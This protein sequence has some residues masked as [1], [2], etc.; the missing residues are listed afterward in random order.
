M[1]SDERLAIGARLRDIRVQRGLTQEEL[2]QNA[3]LSATH[4]SRMEHGQGMSLDSVVALADALDVSLDYVIRGIR[5]QMGAWGLL[6]R[7][8]ED[9]DN[10]PAAQQ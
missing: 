1:T 8:D 7:S 4:I 9:L 5:P 6:F 2:S 3:G 10:H